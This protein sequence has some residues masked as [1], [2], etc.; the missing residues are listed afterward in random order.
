V[1]AFGEV[2][3]VGWR[4]GP[5]RRKRGWIRI[6]AG[7]LM[8]AGGLAGVGLGIVSTVDERERLED[9]AAARGAPGETLTFQAEQAGDYSVFLLFHGGVFSSSTSQERQ[10]R[11]TQCQAD[12]AGA[13]RTVF[14]GARQSVSITLGSASSIGRF[15]TGPGEVTVTCRS[16]AGNAEILVTPGQPSILRSVLG[17]IGGAFV[18]IGGIGLLIWGLIGRRVPA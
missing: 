5:T 4:A 12:L 11:R 18:L 7:L 8:I 6:L 3:P 16:P 1:S 9:D 14:T 17:I 10:V 13:G 2:T 15:G